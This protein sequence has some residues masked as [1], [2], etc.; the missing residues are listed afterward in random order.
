M[1]PT[2]A[3]YAVALYTALSGIVFLALMI[4]AGRVR[5]K[6]GVSIGDGGDPALI[7]A[8]RGQA[9]FVENVPIT[10]L[11]ILLMALLGAPAWLVH[12]FGIALVVGRVLHGWH[13]I[14]QDA[15][16]WQRAGGAMLTFFAQV[17]LILGLIGHAVVGM[18]G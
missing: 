5:G 13:F 1:D 17:A 10:L 18:S 7:R 14:Q 16:A 4:N 8:M 3:L 11:L 6:V 9:N 12:L 15:P 2:P